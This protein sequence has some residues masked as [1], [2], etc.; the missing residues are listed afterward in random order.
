MLFDWWFLMILMVLLKMNQGHLYDIYLR[1][2]CLNR[3]TFLLI[4]QCS[5][6]L[7]VSFSCCMAP[8]IIW[9]ILYILLSPELHFYL[10]SAVR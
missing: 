7:S 8:C 3:K 6:S 5:H 4:T 1:L 2:S 9:Y 10:C